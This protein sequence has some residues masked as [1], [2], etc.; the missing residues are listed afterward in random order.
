MGDPAGA[1][2]SPSVAFDS[3]SVALAR[4]HEGLVEEP[5]A[6]VALLDVTGRLEIRSVP[7]HFGEPRVLDLGYVDRGVPRGKQGRRTY[8]FADLL[9]QRVHLVSEDRAVVGIGVEI[10]IPAVGPELGARRFQ[11]LMA[12]CL[13]GVL[14]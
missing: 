4:N 6:G 9:R 1:A 3:I 12:I 13:E 14:A 2:A 5:Q 7:H 8:R 10:E 11:Q